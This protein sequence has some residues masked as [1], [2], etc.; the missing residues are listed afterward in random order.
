MGLN[1]VL[2]RTELSSGRA[3]RELSGGDEATGEN[4]IANVSER[5]RGDNVSLDSDRGTSAI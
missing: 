3:R 2:S 1:L 5:E 4:T